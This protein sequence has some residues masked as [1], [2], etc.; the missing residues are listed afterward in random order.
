MEIV[1]WN[2]QAW[3]DRLYYLGADASTMS[4]PRPQDTGCTTIEVTNEGQCNG[5]L[6]HA[7]SLGISV[8]YDEEKDVYILGD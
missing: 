5:L 1:E 8:E 7:I 6:T 2:D 3:I 4:V